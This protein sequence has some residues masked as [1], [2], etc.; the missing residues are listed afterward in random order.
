MLDIHT[1]KH[2]N[3]FVTLDSYYNTLMNIDKIINNPYYIEYDSKRRSIKYYGKIDQYV[4]VIVKLD[5]KDVYVST[6][7][8]QSKEKIDKIKNKRI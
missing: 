6:F 4:C 1:N 2:A 7:Y 8:P 5:K 3:N